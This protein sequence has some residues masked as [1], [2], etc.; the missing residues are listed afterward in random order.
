MP[1]L[2]DVTSAIRAG[3]DCRGVRRRIRSPVIPVSPGAPIGRFSQCTTSR[4][5]R[6]DRARS[7]APRGVVASPVIHLRA[8]STTTSA[9]EMPP[10]DVHRPRGSASASPDRGAARRAGHQGEAIV[11]NVAVRRRDRRRDVHRHGDRPLR[12]RLERGGRRRWRRRDGFVPCHPTTPA[13]AGRAARPERRSVDP[14]RAPP[15]PAG[16]GRPVRAARR[17]RPPPARSGA[18][19]AN[20]TTSTTAPA[21][22]QTYLIH[23]LQGTGPTNLPAFS[24]AGGEWSIGWAYRCVLAPN[25]AAKFQVMAGNGQG[26]RRA[27]PGRLGNDEAVGG[28][29]PEPPDRHGSGVRVGD[30]GRGGGGVTGAGRAS[31]ERVC[32][33]SSSTTRRAV[34]ANAFA[35]CS[36]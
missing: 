23:N 14:T 17:R 1:G 30:Y 16:R 32:A 24:I 36:A 3:N 22:P 35:S 7:P 12:W 28:R 25:G 21:G 31:S 2:S 5:A 27:G 33:A 6:V 8:T 19:G 18:T 13:R 34:P 9:A 20:G 29:A 10:R 15:R 11:G 4:P 26:G